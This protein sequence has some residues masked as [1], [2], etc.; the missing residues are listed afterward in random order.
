MKHKLSSWDLSEIKPSGLEEAFRNINDKT[1]VIEQQ[2]PLL[3]EKISSQQF[4]TLLQK[5]EELHI[6]TCKL[7]VYAQLWFAEDSSNQDA[8]A[9]SSRIETFLTKVNNRV[10][11]FNLWFKSL[12]EAK[13]QQLIRASGNIIIS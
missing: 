4:L 5:I 2:R 3:T 6:L 1:N 7:G 11:F 13:A 10:L 8:S 12:P 9:L